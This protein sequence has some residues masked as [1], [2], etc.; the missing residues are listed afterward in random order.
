[1]KLLQ[2]ITL[3]LSSIVLLHAERP[4][5]LFIFADDMAFE[6]VRANGRL[7]ID[8]PNLDR[9]VAEGTNF[10]RSYNMGAWG[11]AV[12][13][14]SRSMLVTG[15]SVWNA[16]DAVKSAST[17]KQLWPQ[18]LQNAGYDTYISGKWHVPTSAPNAFKYS[19]NIR[20]GMPRPIGGYNRPLS[21]KDYETGWKP[22]DK[23]K[24]GFWIGG[25]HWSEVLADDT[26]GF[27]ESAGKNDT[28]FFMYIAFNAPHDPR[29]SPKEYIDKYPL[30]RIELPKTFQPKHPKLDKMC[31]MIR[32]EKTMPFPR[33]EYAVKVNRQEYF[34]L[35]TH[36]DDQ[37]GR[38]LDA[39]EASGKAD[40]TI[41][42]FTADHGLA[43]GHH[44]LAGKQNMYEHSL[45]VP[46]IVTGP[47]IPKGKT[48]DTPIYLQDVMPTT[49]D[50]AGVEQNNVFFKSLTPLIHQANPTAPY[51]EI[52]GAYMNN[53][54]AIIK[55]DWKL[56]HLPKAQAY[57]LYNI[58]QDPYEATNLI[59]QAEYKDKISHLKKDLKALQ[60]KMND[61]LAKK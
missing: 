26:I 27:L 1:M 21:P 41:I 10:T 53:Q 45:T 24:E 28:P 9:L 42:V 20:A 18:L 5:I 47:N 58:K 32:D 7:D 54:R 34:A 23:S 2:S 22:W 60:M 44:G 48:I 61:P 36:M 39:L 50:W 49:L 37:I 13:V 30:D 52:Y 38:I 15:Q 29:Q 57:E 12:C 51:S 4:N 16:Q 14:A 11:G 33:T 43:V 25:K 31:G 3:Y 59:D 6:T 55:G 35:V 8:T 56:I 19:K 40:N 17:N 46:F